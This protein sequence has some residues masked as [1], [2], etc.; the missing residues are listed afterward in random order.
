M[1]AYFNDQLIAVD[2]ITI[3][4]TD[5]AFCYGDGL[6]ETL[7]CQDGKSMFFEQHMMRLKKGMEA[8]QFAGWSR[9]LQESLIA[10]RI[11]ELCQLNGDEHKLM[12]VRIQVWRAEGGLYTPKLTKF[13]LL[14]TAQPT[15]MGQQLKPLKV[16]F[17]QTVRIQYSN[18]SGYKTM[19]ALPYVMA[20]L[21]KKERKLDDLILLSTRDHIAECVASNIF[22]LKNGVVY[23]PSLRAGCVAGIRRE[24]LVKSLRKAGR[25]V[26]R[27]LAKKP[28]LL[29]ADAIF[30]CNVAGIHL[31]AQIE[32]RTFFADEE[33]QELLKP[34]LL[35]TP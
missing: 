26:R 5:R 31:I 22:W 13:N 17:A 7:I 3:P 19:S 32:K 28:T 18:T 14:I 35:L 23:T 25:I 11:E 24:Y 33:T 12:R 10:D 16:G 34:H 1:K 30:N 21:E 15:K 6:F 20:G 27:T 4:I 2:Q 29:N 9:R 8:F